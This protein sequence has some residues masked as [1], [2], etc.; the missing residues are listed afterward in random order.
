MRSTAKISGI[1]GLA[2]FL[3]GLVTYLFTGAIVSKIHLLVGGILLLQFAVVNIRQMGEMVQGRAVRTFAE[4]AFIAGFLVVGLVAVNLIANMYPKQ[5]DWTREGIYSLSDQTQKMLDGL[6]TDVEATVFQQGGEAP[7]A[8]DLL[9]QYS[10]ASPRFSYRIIDPDRRPAMT[11]SYEVRRNG[12]VVL[13]AEGR[14]KKITELSEESLTNGLVELLAGR[15]TVVGFLTGHAERARDEEAPS[16]IGLFEVWLGEENYRTREV[17][18]VQAGR[19]P[20]DVDVLVIAAPEER[21]FAAEVSAIADFVRNGGALLALADPMRRGVAPLAD[22]LGVA[23]SEAMVLDTTVQLFAGPT[24]GTQ[25]VVDQFGEHPAVADLQA[26]A[27]FTEACHLDVREQ[28]EEQMTWSRLVESS[29]ESWAEADLDRLLEME[30]AELDPGDEPGPLAIGLTFTGF[31]GAATV[32][33]GEQGARGAILCDSNFLTNRG[34]SQPGNRDFALN[35][36]GWMAGESEKVSIRPSKR[37]MSNI[38]ITQAEMVNIFYWTVL[39]G[40]EALLLVGLVVWWRRRNQ[41]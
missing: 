27:V 30:E 15:E 9:K 8:D 38:R 24:M 32:A 16:G 34:I 22:R 12:T 6:E 17:S 11:E 40:P 33:A 13:E 31:P 19:V 20:A 7:E 29:A 25:V 26:G 37:G 1:L 41:P 39:I 10:Y 36:V 28:A 14:R 18:V 4:T 3:F 2:L 35:L 5:L 23:I 21:L